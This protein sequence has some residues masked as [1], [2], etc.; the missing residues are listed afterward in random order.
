MFER[1][2]YHHVDWALLAAVLFAL[3]VGRFFQRTQAQHRCLARQARLV[4]YEDGRIA[5]T[6]VLD[7][8]R[9]PLP[10]QF[11][12]PWQCLYFLPLPQGQGSLRPTLGA[13]RSTGS[14]GFAAAAPSASS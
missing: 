3:G 4:E 11:S 14:A 12:L 9:I 2:L 8:R 6:R 10:D 13:C 5:A 7:Q 1:R